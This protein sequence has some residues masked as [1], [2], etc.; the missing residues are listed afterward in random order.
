MS[1]VMFYVHKKLKSSNIT[2][3]TFN[4]KYI[5]CITVGNEP[6]NAAL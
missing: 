2:C 3:E 6:V 4:Q 1:N 5:L